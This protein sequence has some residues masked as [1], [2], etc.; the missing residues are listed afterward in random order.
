MRSLNS[1]LLARVAFVS[2]AALAVVPAVHAANSAPLQAT[3]SFSE[4]LVPAGTTEC[5]GLGLIAGSGVVSHLGKVSV[6]STDCVNLAGAGFSFMSTQL[7]ITAANG[8]QLKGSYGG[9]FNWDNKGGITGGFVIT[10][11]TG[12]FANAKGGGTVSGVEQADMQA[13]TGQGQIRLDGTISY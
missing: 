4:R 12:R 2:T 5:Q 3:I 13:L 1:R 6:E 11:G 10:G 8:D 9:M 7:V